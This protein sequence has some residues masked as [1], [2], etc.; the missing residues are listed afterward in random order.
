M[1]QAFAILMEIVLPVFLLMGVGFGVEKAFRLDMRTLAKLN[2]CVFVPALVFVK[3]VESDI[4][5][6]EVAAILAF[7]ALHAL[8]LWAVAEA[9]CRWRAL[10]PHRDAVILSATFFNA[11]NYGLP[12]AELAFPGFGV[13]IMAVILL[14]QNLLS[15]TLGLWIAGRGRSAAHPTGLLKV[16]VLYAVAAGLLVRMLRLDIPAPVMGPL[17][18]LAAG[19]VPVALL[20]LGAQLAR[21][22]IERSAGPLGAAVALRLVVSPLLAAGLVRLLPL[23][24]NAARVCVAAAGLPVAVNVFILAAEYDKH[25]ELASQCVFWTTLLSALSMT[26]VLLWLRAQTGAQ[27]G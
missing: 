14:M 8:A 2:F 5:P 26:L 21:T 16:P 3:V 7:A 11:G 13:G 17:S 12:L 9:V 22:R 6:R 10:R 15:F 23:A 27:V 20:T 24:P 18:H 4:A 25:K 1:S 19:L